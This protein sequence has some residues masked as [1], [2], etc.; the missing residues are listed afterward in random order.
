MSRPNTLDFSTQ[1]LEGVHYII[2]PAAIPDNTASYLEDRF[3]LWQ[4]IPVEM[5]V[6]D[7]KNCLIVTPPVIKELQGFIDRLK[8]KNVSLVSVNMSD[9]VFREIKR[10]GAEAQFNRVQNFPGDLY[11][12]RSL[13]DTDLRRL[14]FKYLAQAAYAAVEVA[15]SS[16]VS[17]DENYSAKPEEVPLS[18]FDMVT[19][20][21]VANDFLTAEFRLCSSAPVLE[22]LARAMLGN[23]TVIDQDLME[24]MALELLNIIYGHAKSNL[25]DKESFRLPPV[26][27]RLLRKSDFHRIKRSGAA[28]LH[29]MPMVTPMGSFYVEVDFGRPKV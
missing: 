4:E 23:Q 22:K 17:C 24:S 5:H 14:L 20:V 28:Q 13:S 3:K 21:N 6:L 29:I 25:N 7:F 1:I 2:L 27:P 8:A 11:R 18:Q 9:S 26:I 19:V 16:T 15:L 10:V 12:K